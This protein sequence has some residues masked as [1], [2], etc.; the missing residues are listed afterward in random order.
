MLTQC[1]ATVKN[2]A[3][4]VVIIMDHY[5]ALTDVCVRPCRAAALLCMCSKD[6]KWF[7]FCS[8]FLSVYVQCCAVKM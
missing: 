3:L 7:Y 5:R 8:C 6:V 2:L 4:T 1:K